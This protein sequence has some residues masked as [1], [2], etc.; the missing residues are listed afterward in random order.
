MK[1]AGIIA[2][3]NPLH[4]GHIYQLEETRKKTEAD[5][6]VVAMS[7]SFT[8][9]GIP[10]I[11]DKY[12]RT[13]MALRAGAD[14]VI[15][16][17]V[18]VSTG[19]GE[20]FAKGAVTL[21]NSLGVITHLSFGSESG[22]ITL[23]KK[24]TDFLSCETDDFKKIVRNE[25]TSGKTYPAAINHAASI[26]CPEISNLLSS[27]NNILGIEYLKA[28]K[29]LH[30]SIEP[31]TIKRKGDGYN[32]TKIMSD[33][34]SATALREICVKENI[35]KL[36]NLLPESANK[37]IIEKGFLQN[38]GFL[39]ADDFS[40]LLGGKLLYSSSLTDYAD[41]NEDLANRIHNT[42]RRGPLS[43]SE[44][45]DSLKTRQI[46]Q[47]RIQRAL[48]HVILEIKNDT[49]Q[50]I[51]VSDTAPYIRIL[52]VKKDSTGLL[53][54]IRNNTTVPIISHPANDKKQLNGK[55]LQL[56]EQDLSSYHLYRLIWHNK[57]PA[58]SYSPRE[59]YKGLLII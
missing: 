11:L 8:Q 10:A 5:Y 48:F 21:L 39:I 51:K 43:F 18:S 59:D 49:M 15:E 3:Y 53:R 13:E 17:P 55:G 6:I 4:R 37:V 7:G 58:S 25:L 47:A 30:S 22:D 36:L 2:E 1:V 57:Y 34:P 33:F 24:A 20:F 31:I 54:E 45:T 14:L 32:D 38:K 23:L 16:L 52:G 42:V 19:S 50:T 46:T 29:S 27:P 26:L 28:L 35:N 9:R 12:I 44:L 40:N 56:F 41:I